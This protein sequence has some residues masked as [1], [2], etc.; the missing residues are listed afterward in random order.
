MNAFVSHLMSLVSVSEN[1]RRG[2][3]MP[4]AM[5]PWLDVTIARKAGNSSN[6]KLC[7]ALTGR[8]SCEPPTSLYHEWRHA[9][10]GIDLV[11]TLRKRDPKAAPLLRAAILIE[12]KGFVHAFAVYESFPLTLQA[13]EGPWI[14]HK[15]AVECECEC[16]SFFP[17]QLGLVPNTLMPP[18]LPV[19]FPATEKRR[20]DVRQLA[21]R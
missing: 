18:S 19:A 14:L 21:N 1:A 3:F 7:A 10:G 20:G 8:Y 4:G 15:V 9:A 12:K 5:V 17:S 13:G 16:S 2:Q 11:I 6:C